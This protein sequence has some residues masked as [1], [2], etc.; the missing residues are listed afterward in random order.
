[1]S[2]QEKDEEEEVV[3]E[4]KRER[5]RGEEKVGEEEGIGWK[6]AERFEETR[7]K[8]YMQGRESLESC[9]ATG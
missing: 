9:G 2:M 4:E 6:I 1:M 7:A 8:E 3:M 5:E